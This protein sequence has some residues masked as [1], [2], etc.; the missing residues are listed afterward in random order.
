M[1]LIRTSWFPILLG[2]IIFIVIL[3]QTFTCSK[4]A[5]IT[6]S[7]A[8]VYSETEEWQAPD[9]SEIPFTDEGYLIHYGQELIANT[10]QYLGPQGIIAR[11][12]N[13]MNCQNCHLDA[14]TRLYS[15]SFAAVASTYPK[16]RD[17][18]GRLESIEFRINECMERSLN[19]KALDSLSKE[20]RAMVAYVKWIGQGVPKDIKPQGAATEELPYLDRAADPQK[21][22]T[23]FAM[24]CQRCHGANGDGVISGDSSFYVYPPLW[25]PKSY[26]VSAGMYRLSRLAGFIKNSMPLGATWKEPQL[27][28]EEAWDLAAFINSQPRPLKFFPYDWPNIAKKPVDHPFGPYA[29]SF[30]EQQHKFGPFGPI[31]KSK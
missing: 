8:N 20:M 29:D 16:Y 10:A 4:T 17:R 27:T 25:G 26:N 15:N 6:I 24:K 18:S 3:N 21:G 1:N 2:L 9:T 11:K 5:P 12:S 28:N 31:K 13:G 7:S 19:G 22:Q 30:S 23:I 14:G